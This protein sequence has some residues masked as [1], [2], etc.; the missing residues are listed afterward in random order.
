LVVIG[1]T[2]LM[3]EWRAYIKLVSIMSHN[4]IINVP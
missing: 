4:H 3:L 1:M 2:H